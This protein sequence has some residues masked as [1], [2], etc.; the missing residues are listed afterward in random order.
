MLTT[1]IKDAAFAAGV[2]LS[3]QIESANVLDLITK[4]KPQNCGKDLMRIGS[5]RD[6]GYLVPVDLNGIRYCFSAGVG[7]STDFEDHLA[8]LNIRSFLADFSVDRLPIERP[9]F[10]FDKKYLG[11]NDTD[12]F[13]TIK[14]WKEKYLRDCK[15]DL[16]LKMDIEGAEYEVL[17][18][19]PSSVLETFRIM[20]VEFHYLHKM[21][22]PLV[23]TLYKA[24]FERIL[25]D[26]HVA[27]IHPNNC[28]G[29]V[30]KSRIEVPTTMEFTFY[31]KRR[32]RVATDEHHFP[33][34][35]D[36]DNVA[37]KK[38][39]LLPKCWYC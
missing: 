4:L 37:T 30:R 28:C 6:G 19:T 3:R 9:E 11:A 24:C 35:L 2:T 34:A 27:H 32:V 10:V 16:L 15:E 26:F 21:F 25:R 17:I 8:L 5:D 33:H 36:R 22:D 13:F 38:S 39:L 1:F 18:S 7:T 20:V 29:S 14:S 23:Y 12:I 31:N